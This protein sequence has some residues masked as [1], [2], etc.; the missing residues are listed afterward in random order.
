MV[1]AQLTDLFDNLVYGGVDIFEFSVQK[2][3]L[4]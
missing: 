2:L 1:E 3:P 4:S